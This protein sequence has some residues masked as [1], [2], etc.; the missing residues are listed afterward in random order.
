M[1]FD[2]TTLGSWLDLKSR[3]GDAQPTEPPGRPPSCA[4]SKTLSQTVEAKPC[5]ER[6]G[7]CAGYWEINDAEDSAPSSHKG[8]PKKGTA[9]SL[10][11]EGGTLRPGCPDSLWLS[12]ALAP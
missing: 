4:D 8:C 10:G 12:H 7:L 1:G 11:L 9:V 2:P 5:W 3:L 6:G